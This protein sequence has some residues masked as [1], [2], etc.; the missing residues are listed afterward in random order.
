MAPVPHKILF[1]GCGDIAQRTAVQLGVGQYRFVGLRRHPGKLP[2]FIEP[3]AVDLDEEN[4]LAGSLNELDG[5][6]D[7]VV[8]TLTPNEYS[9]HGY[10]QCYVTNMKKIIAALEGAH[11]LSKLVIFVS[12][13]SVYGQNAGEMID[14]ASV[15][16][17]KNYN[18]RYTLQAE[19][20]LAKSELLFCIMRFSGIYGPGRTRLIEQVKNGKWAEK[21]TQQWTNRIHADDGA[22]FIAHTIRQ[23]FNNKK[24]D[25]LYVVSDDESE[26]LYEVKKRIAEKLNQPYQTYKKNDQGFLGKRCDNSK[27]L[28]SGYRFKYRSYQQGYFDL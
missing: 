19:Q 3:L 16:E 25:P 8:I 10:Q 27:A 24:I 1:V 2:L 20:L 28:N 6:F 18:G 14:E 7:V 4:P 17:P 5:G 11:Q 23:A 26:L 22:G 9:E 15:T 12:S 13:T 21:E